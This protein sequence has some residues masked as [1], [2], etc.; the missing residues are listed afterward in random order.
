[1]IDYK[2]II[3]L[4]YYSRTIQ[5]PYTMNNLGGNAHIYIADKYRH[6]HS[7]SYRPS[8]GE[9]LYGCTKGPSWRADFM[10]VL[11]QAKNH[12]LH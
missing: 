7:F 11:D 5:I 8:T 9:W 3:E 4:V 6:H 10:E 2:G 1:M 12:Y